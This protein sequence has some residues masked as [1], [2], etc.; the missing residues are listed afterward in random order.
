MEYKI[1]IPGTPVAKGR[2][3]LGRYGTYTPK[4]TQE[5]EEYIK[6][7]WI[8][9]FGRI[10]PTDKP[11]AVK[12]IFYMPIPKSANKKQKT[13]MAEGRI[14]HTKKPDTDNLIK[15]VLDALNGIAYK[16]DSMIYKLTAIKKYSEKARTE[17]TIEER[18]FAE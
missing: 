14:Q 10:C 7:C 5:Y 17:L 18:G 16:D 11:L 1:T 6:A 13:E 15:S 8:A 12:V 3:R 2:P 9:K 4:K